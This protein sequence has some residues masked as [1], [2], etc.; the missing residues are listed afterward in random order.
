[1]STRVSIHLH[2]H[3]D[4]SPETFNGKADYIGGIVDIIDDVDTG[5]F[6]MLDIEKYVE[7]FSYEKTDLCYFQSDGHTF[8][9]GIRI[10][11]DD[12]S[13]QDMLKVCLPYKK[14]NLFVDHKKGFSVLIT[15]MALVWRGKMK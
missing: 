5:Q 10:L 13:I 4:F 7:T 2:H 15:I 8:K 9:N 14:A 12:E 11:Y 3:G 6:C 1:M